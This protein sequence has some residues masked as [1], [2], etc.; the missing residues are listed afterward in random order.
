M[1]DF[2]DLDAV[3]RGLAEIALAAGP[4]VMEEYAKAGAGREKA[5]GSPVTAAD[6]RAEA[7]ILERL[8][9]F[10][11]EV[12]VVAEEAAAAGARLVAPRRFFLV[13]PLDGTREFL[14]RNGE[15]TINIGLIE[16]GR[17][18]AGAVFAPALGRVWFG[19]V[20]AFAA[21]VAVGAALPHACA[22]IA[23]R[24]AP[25]ALAA[26]ASRSHADAATEAFLTRLGVGE[27]VS[28]GSSLKF[29]KLAEGGAD[30]YPRFG[31]TM[32]WD[33]AAADAVLRA[34]GGTTLGLDGATL[35]YGKL[36]AG[37]RNVGFVAVGDPLLTSRV[38]NALSAF[39]AEIPPQ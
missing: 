3:A 37:L 25:S 36:D 16:D 31:P 1:T 14:A 6:E 34:A 28:A 10:A 32:E 2:G 19:G 26:L 29:C 33:T 8:R 17:P 7:I 20:S 39:P 5:D 15:F 21:E 18:V 4:A 30:V 11:P 13:D 38:V 9:A 12:A 23:V 27:R 35:R 22:A 24:A